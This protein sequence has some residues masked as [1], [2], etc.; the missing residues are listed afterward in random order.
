M[1]NKLKVLK[2]EQH[3]KYIKYYLSDWTFRRYF[4]STR[5]VGPDENNEKIFDEIIKSL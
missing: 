2:K 1:S 3:W 4:W 5:I